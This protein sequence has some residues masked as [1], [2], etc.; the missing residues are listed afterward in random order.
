MIQFGK[1]LLCLR[2]CGVARHGMA[3][4]WVIVVQFSLLLTFCVGRSQR[5]MR[6]A[7]C[8]SQLAS[9]GLIVRGYATNCQLSNQLRI[10]KL[11]STTNKCHQSCFRPTSCKLQVSTHLCLIEFNSFVNNSAIQSYNNRKGAKVGPQ[12]LRWL[13]PCWKVPF[14]VCV[15][16]VLCGR[17]RCAL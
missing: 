17:K 14:C 1:A 15:K 9:R 3:W 12:E 4:R 16:H 7:C 5:W 13:C 11:Q 2:K 6:V 10:A 8:G